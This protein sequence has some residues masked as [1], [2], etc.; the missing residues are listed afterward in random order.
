MANAHR[1]DFEKKRRPVVEADRHAGSVSA[2]ELHSEDEEDDD[3]TGSMAEDRL[4]VRRVE[5]LMRGES[6][7]D[8]E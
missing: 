4:K 8:D 2:D 5:T 3:D 1:Q 6:S 7:E